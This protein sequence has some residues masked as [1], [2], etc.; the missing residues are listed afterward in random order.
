MNLFSNHLNLFVMIVCAAYVL[1]LFIHII[2][3]HYNADGDK[4]PTTNKQKQ[5]YNK[6]QEVSF[7]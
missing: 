1:W 4:R 3:C 5:H 2:S 7:W 6:H